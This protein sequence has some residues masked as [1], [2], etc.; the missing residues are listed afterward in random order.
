[1]P[2]IARDG[3]DLHYIVEGEG[4]RTLMLVNGLADD[5]ETWG[6]QT[7]AFLDAGFKVV[8]FDN[9]G[10]GKSGRPP[11]P[12]TSRQMAED[13]KALATHLA[14]PPFH[15]LGVSMGGMIAQEYA[16]A[17]PEDLS[18]VMLCCT[19]A[20]PG[21]FC[22]RIF[23]LW[24]DMAPAMGVPAIMRDVMLW[25]FTPEFF[26]TR[27]AELRE[28][29]TAM[30]NLD[31]STAA[32]LAQLHAI[33]T[34]DTTARLASLRVSCLALA[35]EADILIPVSQSRKLH[36]AIPQ[37]R[38]ATTRGGHACLWEYPAAFNEAILAFLDAR[39]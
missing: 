15:L 14:L 10:I 25:A 6:G 18:S 11:G 17:W 23:A 22:A 20:E 39:G 7:P 26:E 35:G 13:A 24:R 21:P 19:Y 28:F 8:R 34:H 5:C 30:A 38:W 4:P 1:M 29:E 31:Q 3:W 2:F 27:G 12:Y 9:R 33:E 16:L 37:S 32:Y 36:E